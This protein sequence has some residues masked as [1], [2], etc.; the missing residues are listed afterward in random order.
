MANPKLLHMMTRN[1]MAP[2]DSGEAGSDGD[3]VSREA[4]MPKIPINVTCSVPSTIESSPSVSLS[5]NYHAGGICY[6]RRKTRKFTGSKAKASASGSQESH[7]KK[8]RAA[9]RAD[10]LEGM[11]L[12]R[13]LSKMGTNIMAVPSKSA[14]DDEDTVSRPNSSKVITKKKQKPRIA[15]LHRVRRDISAKRREKISRK[16]ASRQK[17]SYSHQIKRLHRI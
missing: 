2:H 1:S 3:S 12:L 4:A 17:K 14:A 9:L 6:G 8:V 15:P 16:Y 11:V 10:R 5:V 7:A 13:R